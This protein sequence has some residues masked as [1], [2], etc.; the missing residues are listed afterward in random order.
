[1]QGI[2]H[3]P[4]GGFF[5]QYCHPLCVIVGCRDSLSV[6][7]MRLNPLTGQTSTTLMRLCRLFDAARAYLRGMGCVQGSGDAGVE[8]V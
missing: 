8:V 6:M 3:S 4:F 7:R 5:C 1:M 2:D